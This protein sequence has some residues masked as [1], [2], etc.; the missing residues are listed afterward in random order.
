MDFRKA[1]VGHSHFQ[2]KNGSV[3][4]NYEYVRIETTLMRGNRPRLTYLDPYVGKIGQ[5]VTIKGRGSYLY[6]SNY[7]GFQAL[8]EGQGKSVV[9]PLKYVSGF[10]HITVDLKGWKAGV[11]N[12][13]IQNKGS[14]GKS[15]GGGFVVV[16]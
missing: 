6:S 7:T 4:S 8:I 13:F 10:F 5:K 16:P 15:G 1:K 2:V 9:L 14:K 11:Y 12:V 3:A